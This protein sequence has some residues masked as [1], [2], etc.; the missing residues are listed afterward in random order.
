MWIELV[1]HKCGNC[2]DIDIYDGDDDDDIYHDD[3][4]NDYDDDSDDVSSVNYL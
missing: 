1:G 2:V 3:H 4:G